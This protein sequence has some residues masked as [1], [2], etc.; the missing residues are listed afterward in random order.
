M[1]GMTSEAAGQRPGASAG[2]LGSRRWWVLAVMS[3]GALII[4]MDNTVVN[5]ALPRIALDLRASTSTLQWVVDSYVLLL[6]GLLLLAGSV[7]DRF[8]RRRWM[9][10]GL[11]IFG[12]A[13]AG[14]ALATSTSFLIAMR[15]LQ[16]LGA[17][18]VLPATLSI[19][20]DVFPRRERAKAIGIWTGVGALAI[21]VG[22]ALGGYLVTHVG[23]SAVFWLHV[24]VVLAALAGLFIVPESRDERDLGLDVPGAIL[25]TVG[26]TALVFGIIQGTESG[27][28]SLE[29]IGAFSLA[30]VMLV[31]F[32]LVEL[33]TT[34]PMLPLRFFRQRD[35]SGAVLVIGMIVFAMLAA[36]FS[37]TQFLQLVQGRSAFQAGLFIISA[38]AAMMVGAPMAGAM[39][40]RIGPKY[41]A[42]IG[43]LS[44]TIGM[45]LLSGLQ[46]DGGS[47]QVVA[48]L[49]LFG[50]GG[51]LVLAPLTDTVMAAVP[52]EDAGV[53]SAVN[54]VSRELGGALGVAVIGTIVNGLYSSNVTGSLTG[55]APPPFVEAAGE[56]IGGAVLASTGVVDGSV[57]PFLDTAKAA[58]VDAITAGFR[59]SAAIFVVT[60]LVALVLLPRRMRASQLGL[61]EATGDAVGDER[62]MEVGI[63]VDP[64]EEAAERARSV[65]MMH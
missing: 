30:A 4:F 29:I 62:T 11:A 60:L 59:I 23:W 22:P 15:G 55:S 51:G 50:F 48:P 42:V 28:A 14:A 46:I 32:V 12:I 7:G 33:R 41:L 6:A 44:M 53:G 27:W 65:G 40:K 57:G 63:D 64:A 58:F 10:I 38:A 25:G 16:G 9:A 54:D 19:V 26:I 8:G 36:F 20:T 43:I 17:A 61:E 39:V 18:F 1:A 3:V 13:S 49:A 2:G 24:P 45:M 56:G 37:L 5:T 34:H 52:V 47:L 21:G 35:F 31:A